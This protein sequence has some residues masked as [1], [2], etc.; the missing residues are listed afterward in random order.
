MQIK[1]IE[2]SNIEEAIRLV[3][4]LNQDPANKISYFGETR[5]EIE[6]DFATVQP[7]EG[8]C[9]IA[10]SDQGRVVGFCGIEIDLELGRSWL[11]GPLVDDTDWDATADLLYQAILANL[12]AEITNQELYFPV[13]NEWLEQFAARHGFAYHTAGAVLLLDVRQRQ[14]RDAP[15]VIEFDADYADQ[16]GSLHAELFPKTY[17]SAGQLIELARQ[18]DKKMLIQTN[19]EQLAGYIFVQL[20]PA[21]RDMYIDFLG[22]DRHYRRQGIARDLVAKAVE[23]AVEKPYVESVTLTVGGDNEAAISLYHSLGFNTQSVARAYR[24]QT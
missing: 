12:P 17:Y 6:A 8:Y 9:F 16:L 21:S 11:L 20:R 5:D 19:Q 24:K 18:E 7:P 1:K 2:A 22:V 3:F 15:G 23:W 14:T 13:Q 4:L 10:A